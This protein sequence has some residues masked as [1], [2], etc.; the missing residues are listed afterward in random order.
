[1]SLLFRQNSLAVLRGT[2][3]VELTAADRTD[4]PA[5]FLCLRQN[6]VASFRDA[7]S[8][9]F[10]GDWVRFVARRAYAMGSLESG[11]ASP[12]FPAFFLSSLQTALAS[13]RGVA[14]GVLGAI[15][16][17]VE[18]RHGVGIFPLSSPECRGFVSQREIASLRGQMDS[19]CRA[20]VISNRSRGTSPPYPYHSPHFARA[21]W[22]RFAARESA[23]RTPN[24]FVLSR[25][26]RVVWPQL[27]ERFA[28]G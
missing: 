8:G 28:F 22:V 2:S 20:V 5:F 9:A 7:A 19:I 11:Q 25:R 12:P 16:F 14:S 27:R 26:F 3:G 4:Q 15:R 23:F 24:G 21:P 1:M 17:G 10:A 13:F 6:A 18:T